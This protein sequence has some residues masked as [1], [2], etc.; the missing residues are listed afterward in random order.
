MSYS[1]SGFWGWGRGTSE[2]R[3]GPCC[4]V[5]DRHL[6]FHLSFTPHGED[7]SYMKNTFFSK[8]WDFCNLKTF[9]SRKKLKL[10]LHESTE[11][12]SRGKNFLKD[13]LCRRLSTSF[14]VQNDAMPV[15]DTERL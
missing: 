1:L 14:L 4:N 15:N 3:E 13:K 6:N 8:Y 10:G 9:K 7:N 12:Q 2:G 11:I 5:I